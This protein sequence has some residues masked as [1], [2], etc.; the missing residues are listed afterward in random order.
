MECKCK[1]QSYV[2]QLSWSPNIQK[3]YQNQIDN[4]PNCSSKSVGKSF[5]EQYH[6]LE[7]NALEVKCMLMQSLSDDFKK[8]VFMEMNIVGSLKTAFNSINVLYYQF[9][10]QL[11]YSSYENFLKTL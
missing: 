2:D 4:C 3:H 6:E 7:I 5:V 11:R 9:F 10:G 8:C 1:T